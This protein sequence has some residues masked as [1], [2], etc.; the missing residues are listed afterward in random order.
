[1]ERLIKLG[2]CD[3]SDKPRLIEELKVKYGMSNGGGSDGGGDGGGAPTA[4]IGAAKA[5]KAKK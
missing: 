2:V 4:G 1:M 5:K 3:A